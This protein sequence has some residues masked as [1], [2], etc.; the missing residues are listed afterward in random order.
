MAEAQALMVRLGVL[1]EQLVHC[2]Y[3][4]SSSLTILPSVDKPKRL[5]EASSGSR[6]ATT[7]AGVTFV[8]HAQKSYAAW[9]AQWRRNSSCG[10]TRATCAPSAPRRICDGTSRAKIAQAEQTVTTA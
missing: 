6:T 9:S 1:P 2:A 3:L 5:S 10:M 4:R 8:E 7:A